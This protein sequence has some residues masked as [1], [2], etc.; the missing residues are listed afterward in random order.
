MSWLWTVAFWKGREEFISTLAISGPERIHKQR[1]IIIVII[2]TGLWLSE[3][4][5]ASLH[6]LQTYIH[7]YFLYNTTLLHLCILLPLLLILFELI[8]NQNM[9]MHICVL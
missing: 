7:L 4:I 6:M 8:N 5:V 2:I 1:H 3:H 9:H